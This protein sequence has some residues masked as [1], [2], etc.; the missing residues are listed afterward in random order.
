MRFSKYKDGMNYLLSVIDVVSKYLHV[1]PLKLKTG[2][3]V[4]AAF[5]SV[6]KDRR[7]PKPLRRRPVSLQTEGGKEFSNRPFQDMS[8][9]DGIQFH[10]CRNPDVKCVVV[11]RAHR[12]LTNK[13]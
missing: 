9:R 7:Y 1:V 6:L 8:K 2:P 3:S 12:T 4:T 11:E 13:L 5:L 10:V